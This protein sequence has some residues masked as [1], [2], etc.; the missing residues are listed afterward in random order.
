M[1]SHSIR[2]RPKN[3]NFSLPLSFS[4]LPM[5]PRRHAA[6]ECCF[7]EW[8]PVVS[9]RHGF[10]WFTKTHQIPHSQFSPAIEL[11]LQKI[12]LT[13][14]SESAKNMAPRF[15]FGGNPVNNCCTPTEQSVNSSASQIIRTQSRE[16]TGKISFIF[17]GGAVIPVLP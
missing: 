5:I 8:R 11:I 13:S 2:I 4:P 7:L 6:H 10:C 14:F 17:H 1:P 16:L 12:S 15:S 3:L 9:L